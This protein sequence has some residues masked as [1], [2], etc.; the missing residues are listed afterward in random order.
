[1]TSSQ[2]IIPKVACA[3]LAISKAEVNHI[4]NID[5]HCANCDMVFI[6]FQNYT[7]CPSC[8]TL[9]PV[10]HYTGYI[11][12]LVFHMRYTKRAGVPYAYT[13]LK[14]YSYPARTQ[15]FIYEMFDDLESEDRPNGKEFLLKTIEDTDIEKI[16]S[17]DNIKDITIALYD[18]YLEEGCFEDVSNFVKITIPD[19]FKKWYEKKVF[20]TYG[21]VSK[22]LQI[23]TEQD[24]FKI[25]S[26]MD[27]LERTEASEGL[28]RMMLLT[29]TE[30]K[31]TKY[32]KLLIPKT[33]IKYMG[34]FGKIIFEEG[35]DGLIIRRT[36][37]MF[38]W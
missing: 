19:I 36:L 11:E 12:H 22:S 33:F 30:N 14:S 13:D 9:S 24:Y 25:F 15:H 16:Y 18:I 31:I 3:N 10:T 8:K 38:I 20:I 1:M 17:K 6:P 5:Y 7:P 28:A 23:F 27:K 34:R 26:T 35:K 37:N 32:G 2:K 4:N 21:P 29:T